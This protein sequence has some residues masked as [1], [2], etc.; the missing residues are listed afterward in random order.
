MSEIPPKKYD[1]LKK[2]KENYKHPWFGRWYVTIWQ[3]QN[4]VVELG[5]GGDYSEGNYYVFQARTR[6][7]LFFYLSVLRPTVGY[8]QGKL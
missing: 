3:T 8:L 7:F 4:L 6:T 5:I 1:E 2:A